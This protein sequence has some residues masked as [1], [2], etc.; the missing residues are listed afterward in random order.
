M[1]HLVDLCFAQSLKHFRKLKAF[2]QTELS[3]RANVDRTFISMLERGTR[4]PSLQVVIFIAEALDMSA[5]ELVLHVEK[6]I[7]LRE[8]ADFEVGKTAVPQGKASE[9]HG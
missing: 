9:T 4:K 5:S 2:S 3:K 8:K 7:S 1:P 6:M